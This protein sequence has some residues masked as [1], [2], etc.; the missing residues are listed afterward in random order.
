MQLVG[1]FHKMSR[2]FFLCVGCVCVF[3]G[4]RDILP[5]T[6]D[7]YLS[8]SHVCLTVINNDFSLIRWHPPPSK[9]RQEELLG[10]ALECT[11][12]SRSEQKW[13][14]Q[15][16]TVTRCRRAMAVWLHCWGPLSMGQKDLSW[17][18]DRVDRLLCFILDMNCLGE[19]A[20]RSYMG[21]NGLKVC[22]TLPAE[23][24]LREW[25][26]KAN[27]CTLRLINTRPQAGL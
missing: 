2:L 17:S 10:E 8:N 16:K 14:G 19:R 20:S 12:T 24:D 13:S 15:A 1:G 11:A 26:Q 3:V 4:V 5:R 6:V 9:G 25:S 22:R 23:P 18:E 7:N 21:T 27:Q